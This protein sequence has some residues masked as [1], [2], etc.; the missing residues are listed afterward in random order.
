MIWQW[1]HPF[2][3]LAL[4]PWALIPILKRRRKLASHSLAIHG[5]KDSYSSA[6][7]FSSTLPL[8][9]IPPS[10][11]T[12]FIWLPSAMFWIATG[13][14][15]VAMARP[16]TGKSQAVVTTEG[17][18]IELVV[19]RSTSMLALDF[20]IDD[21]RVDRLT[22][23]KH[24]ATKFIRGDI[25]ES[26]IFSKASQPGR[27]NDRIGL[28]QFAGFADALVP[29]TLDHDFLVAYL[30][31]IEF[32][33]AQSEAGTAIGDSLALAV[34]KLQ[35]LQVGAETSASDSPTIK[36]RVVI[37]LTD[38]EN[39]AGEI[40]PLTAAELAASMD[41]KVY[42]IGVGTR[43]MAPF[44]VSRGFG[45]RMNVRSVEVSIDEETLQAIAQTTGGKYYRATDTESL[46]KIYQEI[47]GLERTT[48]RSEDF[49]DYR[50]WAVQAIVWKTWRLPA[51][52]PIALGLVALSLTLR[53]T[54]FRSITPQS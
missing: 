30:R 33:Y 41:I 22:A 16:R 43:G 28:V 49:T 44:P 12:K 39:T 7:N 18:A 9:D 48:L 54:L 35:G 14:G 6:I 27:S 37:L 32:A 42:T 25:S 40:E 29:P 1:L 38:G 10:W 19:D 17:I 36:S 20:Q 47:D 52:V 5:Q 46:T 4:I 15:I 21:E 26:S 34:E 3:L 51:L 13:I 53:A 24:V 11:K 31:R 8:D 45:G 50:E 2:W 23:V